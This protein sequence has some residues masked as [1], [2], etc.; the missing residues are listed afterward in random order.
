MPDDDNDDI[1]AVHLTNIAWC[2]EESAKLY[3][4]R[5]ALELYPVHAR[6]VKVTT[7]YGRSQIKGCLS[8][9]RQI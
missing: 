4:F 8:G 6:L 1:I 2:K 5:Y 9:S 3:L 7:P